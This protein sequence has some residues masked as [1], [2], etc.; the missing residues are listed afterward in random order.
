MPNL[1]YLR[2]G[3][4]FFTLLLSSTVYGQDAGSDYLSLRDS[5]I[6]LSC[7]PQE[8]AKVELSI[9]QLEGLDPLSFS[10]NRDRYYRDLAWG[11]YRRYMHSKDTA[12]ARLSLQTY[13]QLED[14]SAERWNRLFLHSLLGECA[15]ALGLLD[16]HLQ[17]TPAEFHPKAEYIKHIRD[18]CL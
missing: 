14:K 17:Q 2:I 13:G 18:R 5:L 8:K 10:L 7:V 1:K 16:E 6:K 4:L 11:Y 3:S 15:Q 12:D 9:E